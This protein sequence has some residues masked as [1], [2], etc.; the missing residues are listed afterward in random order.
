MK[1]ILDVL[2]PNSQWDRRF[3]NLLKEFPNHSSKKISLQ[4]FGL[5]DDY[6]TWELWHN[7]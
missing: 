7:S 3:T 1:Q 4:V 5:I 6:H 2:C